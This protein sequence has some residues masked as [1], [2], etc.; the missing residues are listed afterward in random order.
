MQSF[1][2]LSP[3]RLGATLLALAV[4]LPLGAGATA[5]PA[6]P[7]PTADPALPHPAT[8][9]CVVTLLTRQPFGEKGNGA[10]MDAAPHRF[11]YRPPAR[12]PGPW[13]K[14]VL[15]A[16][17]AVDAGY[18]YDRTVSLWLDHVN[19]YFGT[20]QEPT[21][22]TAP[23]WR[24]Q[25]DLTAY[26]SLFRRASAGQMRINNWL[27]AL[28]AS[29]I[30]AS[31]KLLFYPANA[32]FP[33]PTVPDHVYAL[34]S[35]NA[36]PADLKA[37][38]DAL[39]R[40]LVF[41]RNT[42]RVYLDLF[43]QPQAHDEFYYMCLPDA[44]IAQVGRPPSNGSIDRQQL[45]GGGSFREAEVSIDGQ[46]A[47]LAPIAPWVF[48]GGIDP[49]LWEPTPGAQTLN[50]M[51]YRV[52][53]T[54]F[55]GL[56]SDGGPHAVSVRVLGAPNFF[57][58]A[59]A[60]LVYDAAHA[61]H[62]GGAITRNTLATATLEPTVASTLARGEAG[63]HGDVSTRARTR[64]VITG[65]LDTPQGRVQSRV[66][67]T[68]HFANAQQFTEPDVRGRGHRVRQTAAIT[69]TSSTIAAGKPAR[70]LRRRVAY[71]LTVRT[72]IRESAGNRRQRDVQLEQR[73]HQ[74]VVQRQAG[75]P[76]Y[77]ADARNT[78]VGADRLSYTQGDRKSFASRHQTSTQTYRFTDSLGDCY[79]A[80]VQAR[81]GKVVHRSRGQGCLDPETMRWFVHPDGS[82]DDFGWRGTIKPQH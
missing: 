30:Y 10:R 31:A 73:F 69:T 50:F 2:R 66:A 79:D 48:T 27:D 18:Q 57:A 7:V 26:S 75:L 1:F 59:G 54:P 9:P 14:V 29:P 55:A 47:G 77:A 58:M 15:Q 28:R 25:R 62:T 4:G 3:R 12:C 43:A 53:L 41:P 17:F 61:V 34:N 5:I 24:V 76:V 52:D 72:S 46:P 56:L 38:G 22:T 37:A 81:D 21:P 60:L 67:A 71:A 51:P 32:A 68:I 82:P 35:G 36:L 16:D 80:Q 70:S 20:T 39:T 23:S 11:S 64:Y 19:L 63:V 8:T 44:V 45:C 13:A 49:F 40:K 6:T 78:H 42:A 33:A 65:Y 74:H